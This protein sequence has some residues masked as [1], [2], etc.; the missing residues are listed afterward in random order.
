MHKTPVI[1]LGLYIPKHPL[2]RKFYSIRYTYFVWECS[3]IYPYLSIVNKRRRCVFARF[4]QLRTGSH[5]ATNSVARS[6]VPNKRTVRCIFLRRASIRY[7]RKIVDPA[8]SSRLLDVRRSSLFIYFIIDRQ[9]GP[10]LTMR[11]F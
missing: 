8:D 5:E 7:K 4:L 1:L 2:Q 9:S 11:Q 10:G 3:L 6:Y